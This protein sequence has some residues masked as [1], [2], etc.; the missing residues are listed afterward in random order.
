M[1]K[2]IVHKRLKGTAI[3]GEV[4]FP[5]MT[6]CECNNNIIQYEGHDICYVKSEQ[7]HQH[8]A[9]DEDGNGLERGHLTQ[10]IMKRLARRDD[11][12]QDR[13]DKI[14]ADEVCQKYKRE[15]YEDY[16][17]WNHDFFNADIDDLRYIAQMIGAKW[18]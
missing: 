3:C 2:Y 9:I 15:E 11:Y 8:F 5:A 13:W 7:A 18:E 12:Y 14:W 1:T 6:I 17:L 10:A 16:W 4:N